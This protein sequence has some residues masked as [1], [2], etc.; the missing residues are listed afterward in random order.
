MMKKQSLKKMR[1]PVTNNDRNLLFYYAFNQLLS[2][3]Q[4]G[5]ITDHEYRDF[6]KRID[7]KYKGVCNE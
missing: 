3:W 6:K 1:L 4:E 2:L 7:E 5:I